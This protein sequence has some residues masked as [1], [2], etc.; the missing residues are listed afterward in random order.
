MLNELQSACNVKLE[1]AESHRR[2]NKTFLN[3]FVVQLQHFMDELEKNTRKL[4]IPSSEDEE[5]D[6]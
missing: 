4:W 5:D 1:N 3:Y 2:W 6:I